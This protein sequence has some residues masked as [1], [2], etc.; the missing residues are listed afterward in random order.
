MYKGP[1]HVIVAAND[2]ML[3]R[4]GRDII[5]WP[6]RLA[7]PERQFREAQDA[8][9]EVYATGVAQRVAVR[10]PD[11]DQATLGTMSIIPVRE[12]DQ[13]IGLVTRWCPAVRHSLEP[14]VPSSTAAQAS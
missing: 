7:F 4:C 3:R 6:A 8:M 10:T 13:V 1:L 12:G 5:G 2:E 11:A 9:D 14:A